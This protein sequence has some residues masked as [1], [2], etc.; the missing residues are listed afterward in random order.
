VNYKKLAYYALLTI[1]TTMAL[2]TVLANVEPAFPETL[3][4]I[5]SSRRNES[6]IGYPIEAQAGNVTHI[7]IHDNR[8]SEFWQGYYGN[9][10]GTI[11]LQDSF[12]NTFFSWELASPSGEVYA[13]N[14]STKVYWDNVTCV[15]LTDTT[16]DTENKINLT[17]LS[18]QYN[19]NRS[20]TTQNLSLEGFNYT[21][22]ESI[23]GHIFSVGDNYIGDDPSELNCPVAYPFVDGSYQRAEFMNLLL[24]DNDSALLFTALLY[25]NINDFRTDV[26]STA[27]FQML[28]AEDGSPRHQDLTTTYYFYVEL[29]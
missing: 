17:T 24:Y 3:T 27:D 12:N 13:T 21:F 29:E 4:I 15:N 18:V 23:A 9:V 14:S 11:V 19:M 6:P 16:T 22:N 8:S 1:M 10:S 2:K 20:L 28:V 5:N 26:F 25:D 7:N